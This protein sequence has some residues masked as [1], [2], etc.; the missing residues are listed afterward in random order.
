MKFIWQNAKF[1]TAQLRQLSRSHEKAS[2]LQARSALVHAKIAR[3]MC[4]VKKKMNRINQTLA[5]ILSDRIAS[6]RTFS[7]F[8]SLNKRQFMRI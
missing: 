2:C 4:C 5:F 7:A 6:H 3:D 1:K 8:M